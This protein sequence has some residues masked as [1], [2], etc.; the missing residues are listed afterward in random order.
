MREPGSDV[1]ACQPGNGHALPGSPSRKRKGWPPNPATTNDI[2]VAEA[3]QGFR[4]ARKTPLLTANLMQ[5]L[6]VGLSG[7]RNRLLLL[8]RA[9][10]N[11]FGRS[12]YL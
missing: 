11:S 3:L 7:V 10:V 9:R 4:A 5:V 6:A 8:V 12:L 1:P 2:I